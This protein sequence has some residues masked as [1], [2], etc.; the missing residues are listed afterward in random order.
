M[1]HRPWW[2]SIEYLIQTCLEHHPL[3]FTMKHLFAVCV[4]SLIVYQTSAKDITR[5]N[6]LEKRLR[7]LTESEE[8][9]ALERGLCSVQYVK[10][11]CYK[12]NGFK[13]TKTLN[14]NLF[15]DRDSHSPKKSGK[16]IDWHNFGVYLK[17]L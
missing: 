11:G 2:C 14:D 9:I 5:E 8:P 13:G 4:L 6:D 3:R 16:T 10:M 15:T 1:G 17:D 7:D 12:D